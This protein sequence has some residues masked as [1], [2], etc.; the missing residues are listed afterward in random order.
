MEMISQDKLLEMAE[1]YGDEAGTV[2][3]YSEK[4]IY[5]FID[6]VET[7]TLSSEGNP[8]DTLRDKIDGD[9]WVGYLT[10][11]M[12]AFSDEKELPYYSP[13]IPLAQFFRYEKIF[14][15]PR[16]DLVVEKQSFHGESDSEGY[17]E[18]IEKIQ[19][20]IRLGDVYQVNLSH[21]MKWPFKKDPFAFFKNLM[22][23]NPAPFSAYFRGD[24]FSI[25]SSSPERLLQKKGDVLKTRPIKGTAPRGVGEKEDGLLAQALMHSEKDRAELLMITDLMRNDLGKVSLPGSVNV[26]RLI[27]LETYPNVFHLVSEVCSLADPKINVVDLLRAVFPGGSVTGCPKLSAM[28]SIYRH[29]KRARGIYT[30]SIGY[31]RDG[32]FDFN[33]AI[34]TA[35]HQNN[36]LSCG[37]GGAIVADSDP[38]SEYSET[39]HKGASI[40]QAVT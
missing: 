27:E 7:L 14:S 35:L 18:L 37:L 6:P 32:D 25:I 31:F 10:Y 11:E 8:W 33:I 5:L 1:K 20:E 36:I 38:K 23:L 34:R 4:Q 22:K 39:L 19:E 29:E 3:L 40:F 17:I 21:E 26:R 30:G 28:E 12:G 2:L 16:S 15:A 24:D 13:T 9:W